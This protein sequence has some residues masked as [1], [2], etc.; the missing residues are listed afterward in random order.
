MNAAPVSNLVVM[1]SEAA[2]ALSLSVR[3]LQRLRVD[4]A[5]PPYIQLGPRRI[6]YRLADLE[7]RLAGRRVA[8][9]SAATVAR[10]A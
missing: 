9:T 7:A 8:S 2:R 3:S 1:E 5:G 10:R 6:G 4:G